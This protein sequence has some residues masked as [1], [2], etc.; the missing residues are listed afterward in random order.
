M[1]VLMTLISVLAPG[2]ALILAP[3]AAVRVP[4]RVPCRSGRP[5][6]TLTEDDTDKPAMRGSAL[7]MS[8]VPGFAAEEGEVGAVSNYY[9]EMIER[10]STTD[11]AH[12]ADGEFEDQVRFVP[13]PRAPG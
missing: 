1:A 13:P 11:D 2:V 4:V 8:E 9:L 5:A 6:L 7:T 12:W 10:L 3:A